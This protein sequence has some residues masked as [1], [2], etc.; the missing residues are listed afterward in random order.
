M[1]S[2]AAVRR[3]A[4]SLLTQPLW[5]GRSVLGRLWGPE[6]AV[7]RPWRRSARRGGRA[8]GLEGVEGGQAGHALAPCASLE[9][10]GTRRRALGSQ[11]AGQR[12]APATKRGRVASPSGNRTPVSRVTGGDTHHYT[13]EDGGDHPRTRPLSGC[14]PT[15]PPALRPPALRPPA[16]YGRPARARPDPMPH[17]ARPPEQQPPT[18]TGTRTPVALKTP[19]ARC[20]LLPPTR[21][22]RREEGARDRKQGCE[23]GRCARRALAGEERR[24]WG[25]GGRGWPDAARLRPGPAAGEGATAAEPGASSGLA[26]RR[27]PRARSVA[28]PH[29]RAPG[30][31][32]RV[33][34]RAPGFAS[35]PVPASRAATRTPSPAVRMAER[36]KALRSGRS[37]PWRRGFE[38]HS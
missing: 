4:R 36:S 7:A 24:G 27:P 6:E 13:N 16:R 32:H 26:P 23:E 19:S 8:G 10:G 12:A 9:G 28:Q 38:S 17:Q 25:A 3:H 20:L 2:C 33:P 35:R 31:E 14:L 37:L 21:G 11:A 34:P 15:P 1:H 5:A 22:W 30:A 18:P 29:G